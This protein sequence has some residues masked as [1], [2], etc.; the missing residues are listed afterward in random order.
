ME[1][2]NRK[3]INCYAFLSI[4]RSPFVF[5]GALH[6]TLNGYMQ[7]RWAKNGNLTRLFRLIMLVA[8]TL[9]SYSLSLS[10]SKPS[11]AQQDITA[12][13]LSAFVSTGHAHED[14]H[15]STTHDCEESE[16]GACCMPLC[17]AVGG[18]IYASIMIFPTTSLRI[19]R[20]VMRLSSNVALKPDR[21]PQPDPWPHG[22]SRVD[23]R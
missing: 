21:P 14:D 9:A 16:G 10:L 12:V 11:H 6:V 13:A 2:R 4:F 15:G 20:F 3:R 18:L 5:D 8:L 22:D 19:L 23:A 7:Q 1:A 17:H